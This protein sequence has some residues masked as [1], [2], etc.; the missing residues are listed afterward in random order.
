[1]RQLVNFWS[2]SDPVALEYGDAPD[3]QMYTNNVQAYYRA[4]HIFMG[5]PT[6]YYERIW[7]PCYEQLPDIEWRREASARM[8][9]E[10]TA[11]TDA[12][13]MSSRDGLHYRR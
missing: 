7:S 2:W 11:L 10:G 6:R 1:M 8:V 9:R 3:Y 5:F 4:P 13:F 12:L